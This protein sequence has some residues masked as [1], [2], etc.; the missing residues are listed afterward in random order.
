MRNNHIER[1]NAASRNSL[2]ALYEN[3]KAMNET[4]NFHVDLRGN[5]FQCVCKSKGF[6]KWFISSPIFSVTRSMHHCQARGMTLPMNNEAIKEAEEDCERPIRRRRMI[7]L[8]S[9]LPAIGLTIL[10]FVL[11]KLA[12]HFQ[13]KTVRKR[14]EDRVRL[15]QDDEFEHRY[16]LFLSYSNTDDVTFLIN[17]RYVCIY[18]CMF[19]FAV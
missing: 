9:V 2:D 7:I 16:L 15:I 11:I 10:I 19:G 4:A 5:P 17:F 8:A 14:F 13:R 12:K 3:R 6:L 18:V 1:L